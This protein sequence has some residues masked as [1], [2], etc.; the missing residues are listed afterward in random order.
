MKLDEEKPFWQAKR[1]I[2]VIYAGFVAVVGATLFL[3]FFTNVFRTAQ[4]GSI[5]QI[6]WFLAALILVLAFILMLSKLSKILDAIQEN[7]VKLER[8]AE[9][10]EKARSILNRIDE[11]VRLS[12]P[13]KSAS[14]READ[15]QAVR[16]AVFDKLQEHDFVVADEMINEI[17]HRPGYERLAEQLR[18][19][20]DEYRDSTDQEKGIQELINQVEK[21][22]D[23]YQWTEANEQIE[24]LIQTYPK[25]EQA[26]A[27]RQNLLDKKQQRKKILLTAW[28]DAI[29]RGATD[30][31]LEI[32]K[33]LDLYLSPSEGLALQEAAKD[34]FK[35]KL[36]NL[37]VQFS[38]AVSGK[39]W[40]KA[41]E[42]GRQITREFPNS[43][44][45]GEIREKLQ[46]LIQKGEK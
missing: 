22:L 3:V 26:K 30:R 21:L 40:T 44:I 19:Q 14:A 1:K 29:K 43:R 12:E 34:V 20:A 2:L 36:H 9:A 13:A 37:G 23:N 5:P 41:L 46:V 17:A 11:G 6:I 27:L 7:N 25:S 4:P 15:K 31:S 33:E 8:I 39:N 45:A 10:L 18:Q 16:Q 38:L 24:K 42:I 32:L 35:T 28:N